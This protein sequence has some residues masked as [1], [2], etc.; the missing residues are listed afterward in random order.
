MSSPYDGKTIDLDAEEYGLL[1]EE[2]CFI[3]PE[4]YRCACCNCFLTQKETDLYG[5]LC[6]DCAWEETGG[7]IDDNPEEELNFEN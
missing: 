1:T 7:L 4:E 2:E 3:P 6:E 5:D